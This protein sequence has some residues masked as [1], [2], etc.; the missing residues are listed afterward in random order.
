MVE[1]G[2]GVLSAFLRER[3]VDWLVVT[4]SPHLVGGLPALHDIAEQR[5]FLVWHRSIIVWWVQIY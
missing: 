3:L 4:I 5:H 2:Q 1:G